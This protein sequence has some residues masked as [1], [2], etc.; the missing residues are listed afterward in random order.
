MT[1]GPACAAVRRGALGTK[2]PWEGTGEILAGQQ[3]ADL[4]ED[5][6]P[7][8]ARFEKKLIRAAAVTSKR[9]HVAT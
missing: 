4:L 8:G 5:S 2:D 1:M 9:G 6:D 7:L 3:A